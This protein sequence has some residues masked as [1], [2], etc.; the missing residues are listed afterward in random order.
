MQ[1]IERIVGEMWPGVPVVPVMDPWATDGFH[2]RRAGTPVYGVPGIF[3]EIDP[4]RAHGKDERVG[5]QA[6]HEGVEFMYRLMRALT[7]TR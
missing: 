5:V 3:F 2:L 1:P 4:L 7:S 6:F